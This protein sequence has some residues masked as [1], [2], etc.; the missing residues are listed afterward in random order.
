MGGLAAFLVALA[1]CAGRRRGPHLP[2]RERTRAVN[3][4]GNQFVPYHAYLWDLLHGRAG[5]PLLNWR[6]GFGTSLLPDLGTYL[7]SPFAL[8][9]G[10]FP[11]GPDRLS[12][13]TSSRS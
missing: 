12:P 2:L 1:V 9:V 8:L 7:T 13:C 5:G 10:V 3:D 11:R 4:L 6:A